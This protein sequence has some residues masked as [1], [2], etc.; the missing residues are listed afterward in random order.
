M[1]L[2]CAH[3]L[4]SPSL[5]AFASAVLI[6]SNGLFCPDPSLP[7]KHL[8]LRLPG[9]HWSQDSSPHFTQ[10][11]SSW[12][13]LFA[14]L[15][16]FLPPPKKYPFASSY[17]EWSAVSGHKEVLNVGWIS[18]WMGY[19]YSSFFTGL[20]TVYPL[21]QYVLPVL[22]LGFRTELIMALAS[23]NISS[24]LTEKHPYSMH[25]A[26]HDRL[27][28]AVATHPWI[29]LLTSVISHCDSLRVPCTAEEGA[30]PHPQVVP[31]PIPDLPCTCAHCFPSHS[32]CPVLS[33]SPPALALILS[34]ALW[35]G[36]SI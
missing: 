11:A 13:W 4:C 34:V 14:C 8:S 25:S 22:Q 15:S 35:N 36:V 6:T 7:G 12:L 23:P 17:I 30:H 10:R 19:C 3:S 33:L 16:P 21:F 5:S 31:M 28:L 24:C 27:Q 32:L 18:E 29:H 1:H 9:V 26:F 20:L 2:G